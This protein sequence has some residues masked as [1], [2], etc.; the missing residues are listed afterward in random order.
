MD[1]TMT[2]KDC[3]TII[4]V[5]PERENDL[6][7]LTINIKDPVKTGKFVD[8]CISDSKNPFYS[9]Y[10][11]IKDDLWVNRRTDCSSILKIVGDNRLSTKNA[12]KISALT[13][14]VYPKITESDNNTNLKELLDKIYK[15]LWKK[16]TSRLVIRN[17]PTTEVYLKSLNDSS[18]DVPCATQFQ[19]LRDR[20]VVTFRA[21]ALKSEFIADFCLIF[22]YYFLPVYK[23]K[24]QI[25]YQIIANTTQEVDYLKSE[26]IKKF[27]ELL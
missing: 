1:K 19:Y 9:H 11:A 15:E 24:Q 12:D 4:N 8:E 16:D 21:H 27:L 25:S 7:V 3:S 20:F 10:L 5:A 13:G 6:C 26:E 18:V 23:S 22:K 17:V 14:T 2:I